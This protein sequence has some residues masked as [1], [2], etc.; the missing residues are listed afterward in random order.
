[1]SESDNLAPKVGTGK[2]VGMLLVTWL[3]FPLFIGLGNL[4][5][6][7][8]DIRYRRRAAIALGLSLGSTLGV[9]IMVL[10]ATMVF[11]LILAMFGVPPDTAA[12]AS[13]H[14]LIMPTITAVPLGMAIW[15]TIDAVRAYRAYG[16]V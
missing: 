15:M 14:P 9:A 5:W 6:L 13:I 1:M 10:P 7:W 11:T 12:M 2:L 3:T 16:P 8:N 4:L